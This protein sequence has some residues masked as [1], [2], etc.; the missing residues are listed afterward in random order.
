MDTLPPPPL[1]EVTVDFNPLSYTVSKGEA[2]NFVVKLMAV[3]FL[4]KLMA[5]QL[6]YEVN[7]LSLRWVIEASALVI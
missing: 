5:H 6:D 7:C 4:V 2:V 1:I 3:S